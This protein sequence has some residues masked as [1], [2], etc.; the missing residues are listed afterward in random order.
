MLNDIP[1][2][3]SSDTILEHDENLDKA[4]EIMEMLSR[5]TD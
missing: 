1:F 3:Y 4:L 2:L 5:Y